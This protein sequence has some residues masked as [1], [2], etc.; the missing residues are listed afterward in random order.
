MNTVDAAAQRIKDLVSGIGIKYGFERSFRLSPGQLRAK[1]F[2]LGFSKRRLRD[3]AE[4]KILDI[5]ERLGMP[6]I[7]LDRYRAEL[8]NAQYVHFGFEKGES[9]CLYKAY[10]E[11]YE[12]VEAD[13][14]NTAASSDPQLM[15][16][17]F[18]WAADGNA[19]PVVTRYVWH[20]FISVENMLERTGNLLGPLRTGAIME[21]ARGVLQAA[22]ARVQHREIFYMEATEEGNP[23]HSF[24]INM[25][26]ARLRMEELDPVIGHLSAHFDLAEEAYSMLRESIRTSIFGHIAGGTGRSGGD[27]LTIYHGTKRIDPPSQRPPSMAP[28]QR[29]FLKP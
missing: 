28:T 1:R 5:C 29:T 10:L 13:M 17:G 26:R 12:K 4:Q 20:P 3:T 24:D 11:F 21:V 27:F 19:A 15:H 14:R 7:L 16:L 23:R 18:K 25:Y 22:S 8:P 9:G 2:L 6:Q